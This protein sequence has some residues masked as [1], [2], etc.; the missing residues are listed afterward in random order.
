MSGATLTLSAGE[1]RRLVL[2]AQGFTRAPRGAVRPPHLASLA[3]RLGVVQIDSVNALVRSHYLPFFPA[4][5]A[6]TPRRWMR[7]PGAAGVS[8]ASSSTGGTRRHC[9]RCPSTR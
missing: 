2:A 5:A 7:W 9:C 8:G 3:E 6:T 4:W 1:A